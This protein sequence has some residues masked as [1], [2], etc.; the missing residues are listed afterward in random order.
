MAQ[1]TGRIDLSTLGLRAAEDLV[2]KLHWPSYR[3]EQLLRWLHRKR[4]R[5]IDEMTDFSRADRAHLAAI[6]EIK[7]MLP[8]R[9][10]KSE[11]GTEKFL[12]FLEDGLLIE[13][14]LIPDGRR[15]TLCLSTQVGCT[16]DCGF[17]LTGTMGLKR[18]L[19]AHEIV[20][21]VLMVQDALPTGESLS[22]LV[23]MGMGEPLANLEA[24]KEAVA[25][26]TN[27]VWGVGIPAR[28][29]TISTAGLVP[30]LRDVEALGINLAVSLNATTNEQR[31]DLMPAANRLYPLELLMEACRSF[32]VP[33]HRR[34]TFEY[35]LLAGVNDSTE[36]AKRLIDLL[37]GIRCKVNLIALNEFPGNRFRRPSD[38]AV[39]RFQSIL[40]NGGIRAFIR[41]SK[42]R[43]VL[44]ACGQ[45]GR[46]M[47]G[48]HVALTPIEV[49]C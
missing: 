40:N 46:P 22:N 15:L 3:A 27:P 41:K 21:Q 17:C 13:S 49:G 4:I 31:N 48:Q 19:R 36:D 45:L 37:A 25:R 33:P 16:L 42:G 32:R 24:V 26:L 5:H 43:D 34:L 23:L 18:N 11:D 38:A 29:I 7:R 8:H 30:R 14:V 1:S 47:Q 2:E 35:V 39:L 20:A 10:L 9:V 44:G 6:A 28:R 12:A